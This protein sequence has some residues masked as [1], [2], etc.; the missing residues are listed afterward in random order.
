MIIRND[1][2]I[3]ALLVLKRINSVSM[4]GSFV[5]S[6]KKRTMSK[7]S[8]T[9]TEQPVWRIQPLLTGKPFYNSNSVKHVYTTTP[10]NSWKLLVGTM[11]LAM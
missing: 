9:I 8:L 4:S 1:S 10:G 5:F 3:E 7:P 6:W 11:N 2:E